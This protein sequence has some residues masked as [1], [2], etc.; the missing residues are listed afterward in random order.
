MHRL[1]PGEHALFVGMLDVFGASF[2]DAQTYG[3]QR[4]GAAYVERLLGNPAFLG[5]VAIEGSKVVGA[6]AAYELPKFERER[7][8]FY[9]YD[10]AVCEGHR[11]RGIATAL[12]E[13]VRAVARERSA[14]VVFV[15][16]DFGDEPAIALYSRL[17]RREDV[18]H[19]DIPVA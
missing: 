10:L 15:Q 3:A 17:G 1:V 18:L 11:R 12:I 16:A 13:E 9:I 5:L 2:R 7:S 14:W 19:F 8:E 6:L 4:P